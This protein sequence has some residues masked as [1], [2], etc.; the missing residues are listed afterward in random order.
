MKALALLLIKAYQRFVSPHKGFCCAYRVHTGH[1]SCSALGYRTIRRFGVVAGIR[2]LRQRFLLC[3]VAHRRYGVQGRVQQHRLQGGF[4][5]IPC[6]ASCDP[7][8]LDCSGAADLPNC[9]DC[10]PGDCGSAGTSRKRKDREKSNYI[11]PM[12]RP[13]P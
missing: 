12:R 8:V 3:A 5:D 7:S 13:T 6:D 1:G 2:L 11:P 4:C 9:C 10:V